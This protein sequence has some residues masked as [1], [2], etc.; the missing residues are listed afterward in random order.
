MLIVVADFHTIAE[1]VLLVHVF[2]ERNS[3]LTW[4]AGY[5]AEGEMQSEV[6]L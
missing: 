5:H 4:V 2:G 6:S 3:L 1:V